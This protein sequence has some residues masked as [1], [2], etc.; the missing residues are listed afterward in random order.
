MRVGIE[1]AAVEAGVRLDPGEFEDRRRDVDVGRQLAQF[2][3]GLDPRTA[4]QEGQVG[5]GL[6]G[7]ELAAGG[8]CSP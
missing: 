5:G 6:V 4:D 7:E 2:L 8:R 3:P 1:R